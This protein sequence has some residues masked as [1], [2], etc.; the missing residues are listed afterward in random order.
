MKVR[1]LFLSQ[2]RLLRES[3]Q[4]AL[5]AVA[6]VMLMPPVGSTT[7]A[8]ESML[9]CR[10]DVILI[11]LNPSLFGV[12]VVR[13]LREACP[14]CRILVVSSQGDPVVSTQMALA[15][16]QGFLS[17]DIGVGE[18]IAALHATAA[19]ETVFENETCEKRIRPAFQG[20]RGLTDRETQVLELIAQGFANKPVA[21]TLGISIK[22]VEKHRQRVM[23]KLQAH[24]TA[25]LT[26]RAFCLG[27]T[28]TP[29]LSKWR[30]TPRKEVSNFTP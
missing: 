6:D 7:E 16:V 1:V 21:A 30:Q 3:V 15:G 28:H 9:V 24:D 17:K 8:I 13:E 14:D 11:D 27:A 10:P 23:D 2:Q 25:G 20:N 26:W 18:L 4:C 12:R 22:T 29:F 19:G 5:K